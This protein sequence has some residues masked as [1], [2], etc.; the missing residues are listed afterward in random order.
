M[1]KYFAFFLLF[2]LYSKLSF[3][4]CIPL[5]PTETPGF[6]PPASGFPCITRGEPFSATIY[7]ENF[8]TFEGIV[9]SQLRFDSINNLPNGISYTI[10]PD[11]TF[12]SGETGCIVFAGVT[13]DSI[14]LD[15]LDIAVTFTIVGIGAIS[16]ELY[17]I[18]NPLPVSWDTTPC[19]IPPYHLRIINT[20]DSCY[21]DTASCMIPTGIKETKLA[22]SIYPNPSSE[23]FSITLNKDLQRFELQ[24]LA[25]S[26][27]ILKTFKNLSGSNYNF[28]LK[29]FDKGIYFYQVIADNQLAFKGKLAVMR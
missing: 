9:I 22:A 25:V 29:D 27:K 26:G 19:P 15:Y 4:Q 14:G 2:T 17:E 10:Y 1:R 13:N 28:S 16:S 3:S 20:G 23:N 8:D 7:F 12:S 24:L 6:C 18:C 5:P 11:N 21:I